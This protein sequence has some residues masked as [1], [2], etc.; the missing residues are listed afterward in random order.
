MH[1]VGRQEADCWPD[2][3]CRLVDAVRPDF[4]RVNLD[5]QQPVA[6]GIGSQRFHA[7]ADGGEAPLDSPR[8]RVDRRRY[9]GRHR[10]GVCA[11]PKENIQPRADG[12]SPPS[13]VARLGR[14][15]DCSPIRSC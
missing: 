11:F 9:D 6:R 14:T 15:R 10:V 4:P 2:V 7:Y 13:V 5:A 12:A 1:V 3:A 8:L